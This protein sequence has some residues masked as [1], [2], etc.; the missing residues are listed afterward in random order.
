MVPSP[1]RRRLRP[2]RHLHPCHPQRAL[3]PTSHLPARSER[4]CAR[5]AGWHWQTQIQRQ[6]FPGVPTPPRSSRPGLRPDTLAIWRGKMGD[7]GRRDERL[8]RP[9][10]GGRTRC[11]DAG[12]LKEDGKT[13][14]SFTVRV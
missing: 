8:C 9:Q 14:C 1:W 12:Y 3:F 6:L 11:A 5:M 7:G 2:R 10:T 13:P 4:R